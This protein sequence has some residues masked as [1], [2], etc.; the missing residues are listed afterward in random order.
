MNQE[1]ILKRLSIVKLLYKIGIEQS[2]KGEMTSFFSILS[3][4]DSIEMFLKLAV[5]K[6]NKKDCQNFM[7]YWEKLPKLTLK[8][9]MRNLNANRVNL[10]HKGITPSKIDIE[11]SRVNT[12][13]FFDQNAKTYFGIDFKDVSLFELIKYKSTQEL[14]ISAN[15]KLGNKNFKECAIEC[16][17]AFNELLLEYKK[18]K[19]AGYSYKTPFDLVKTVSSRDS[20]INKNSVGTINENFKN[21]E[22]ALQ[23]ISLGIDYKKYIKFNILTPEFYK[24]MQGNYQI[25]E[26]DNKKLT[27][28]NCEFLIDFVLDSA[29]TLQ[30]F[31]FDFSDVALDGKRMST[32]IFK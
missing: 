21:I 22:T 16:T 20:G 11:T 10:K 14:L 26:N 30:D 6:N 15:D 4:H 17:K 2:Y 5:E 18:S 12:T 7:E 24:S 29:L 31:D 32:R 25:R 27:E 3:F 8:E 23:V 1:I 9:A 28:L 13:S 19:S